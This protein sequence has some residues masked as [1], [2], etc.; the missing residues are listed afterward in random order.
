M[1]MPQYV[2]HKE[3]ETYFFAPPVSL[4]MK[5]RKNNRGDYS[6]CIGLFEGKKKEKKSIAISLLKVL[7]ANPLNLSLTAALR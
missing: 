1:H 3:E 5:L 6:L 2:R 7:S 4:A